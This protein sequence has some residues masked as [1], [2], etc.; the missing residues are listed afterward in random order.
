[1]ADQDS[2]ECKHE[3]ESL[4][5]AWCEYVAG[6][7]GSWRFGWCCAGCGHVEKTGEVKGKPHWA[8]K[9]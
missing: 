5:G 4:K 7:N 8:V 9:P 6:S 1:M 2:P 3:N